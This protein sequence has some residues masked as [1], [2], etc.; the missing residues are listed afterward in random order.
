[1]G[2]E[3]R[4]SETRGREGTCPAGFPEGGAGGGRPPFPPTAGAGPALTAPHTTHPAGAP[5][6]PH[7]LW[8]GPWVTWRCWR[9]ASGLRGLSRQSCPGQAR[10][11]SGAG[12]RSPG[13]GTW[14]GRRP[15]KPAQGAGGPW[16]HNHS[17][18][19]QGDPSWGNRLREGQ[20]RLAVGARWWSWAPALVQRPEWPCGGWGRAGAGMWRPQRCMTKKRS[21]GPPTSSPGREEPTRAVPTSKPYRPVQ[22]GPCTRS[23]SPAPEKDSGTS[24][25]SRGTEV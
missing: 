11:A 14:E 21:L 12:V 23:L 16:G 1:M 3:Q 2:G 25:C 8:P 19:G 4:E 6:P 22:G 9:L 15:L 17:P 10:E 13:K 7:V 18:K 24:V 20:C 5:P